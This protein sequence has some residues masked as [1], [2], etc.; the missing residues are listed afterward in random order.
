M[1]HYCLTGISII[2]FKSHQQLRFSLPMNWYSTLGLV[3]LESCQE[4]STYPVQGGES[5]TTCQSLFLL[6]FSQSLRYFPRARSQLPYF[7]LL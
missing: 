3:H 7:V 2:I 5:L 4:L 6:Y 1:A